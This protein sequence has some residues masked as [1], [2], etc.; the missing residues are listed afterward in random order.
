MLRTH[1]S[2]AAGESAFGVGPQLDLRCRQLAPARPLGAAAGHLAT[3]DAV[4]KL[5]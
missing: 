5:L 1:F 3:N 4:F 2:T